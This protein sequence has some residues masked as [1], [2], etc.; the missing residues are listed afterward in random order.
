MSLPLLPSIG[1][2]G[3]R[4]AADDNEAK[5]SLHPLS[6]VDPLL[7]TAS[8]LLPRGASERMDFVVAAAVG[9]GFVGG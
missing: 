5:S 6:D 7:Q 2:S 1:S 9:F 3:R 4:D 8:A